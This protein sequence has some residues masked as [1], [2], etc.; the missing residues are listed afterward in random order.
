MSDDDDNAQASSSNAKAVVFKKRGT[1]VRQD[2]K[3][4]IN[5][6]NESE[7]TGGTLVGD[8]KEDE[9]K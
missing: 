8:A 3:P 6:N 5:L 1:K 4:R 2:V 9:E 7:E